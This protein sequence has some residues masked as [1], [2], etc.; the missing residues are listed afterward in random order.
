M[1]FCGNCG[2]QLNDGAKFCPKCGQTVDSGASIPQQQVSYDQQQYS[3]YEEEETMKMWQKILYLLV[4][5][6]GL[7]GGLVYMIRKKTSMAKSAFLWGGIGTILWIA[8][9]SLGGSPNSEIE[10]AT[11]EIMVEEFKK[12]GVNCVV[13]DL[14]L[15]HKS[16]NEYSGIANCKVDGEEAQFSLNVLCDGTNV[17][18]EWELSSVGDGTYD[19]EEELSSPMDNDVAKQGYDDGYS[20]GFQ[21]ADISGEPDAKIGYTMN[22]GAPSTPAEKRMYQ[23]Y[24]ENY[25]RGYRDGRRAGRE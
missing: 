20:M 6:A 21:M 25:D 23:I 13:K 17:Q 15:V 19:D 1:A 16:G 11:K 12:Q 10:A 7:L 8:I 2:T 24:K 4:G 18:A 9:S 5:P 14:T 22:Y 3:G